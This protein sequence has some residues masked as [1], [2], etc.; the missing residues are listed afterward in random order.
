MIG[1]N[2]GDGGG[3]NDRISGRQ[4][5]DDMDGGPAP[6]TATAVRARTTP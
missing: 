4:G 6:M 5:P 3:G 2:T 1:D